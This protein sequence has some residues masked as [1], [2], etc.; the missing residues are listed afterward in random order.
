MRIE[1]LKRAGE[2]SPFRPFLIRMADGS[3]IRM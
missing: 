2:R 1:E 3:E